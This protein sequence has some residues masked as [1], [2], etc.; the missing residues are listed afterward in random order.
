MKP[1]RI[2]AALAALMTPAVAS[3]HLAVGATAP[4]LRTQGALAGRVV[5]VDLREALRKGPVVLYFYPAA[6]TGG[7][8]MQ[9]RAFSEASEGF[10]Q[11]GATVIGMSGDPIDKLQ[12]FSVEKCAGKFV[13]G[14][15]TPGTIRAFDVA[16]RPP[17]GASSQMIAQMGSRSDRTT[18][19][20]APDGKIAFVYSNMSPRD[21]VEQSLA[22]VRNLRGQARAR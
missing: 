8:D 22:A 18:Y 21:H 9:A 10:A 12:K 7:C 19:V 13:V 5:D 14:A 11:A 15:A 4:A 17:A 1:V 16:F 6:F 3:A 20:I 2:I